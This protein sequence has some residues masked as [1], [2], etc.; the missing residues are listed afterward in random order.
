MINIPRSLIGVIEDKIDTSEVPL[1]EAQ[2]YPRELN[3]NYTDYL[4]FLSSAFTA[5]RLGNHRELRDAAF[6]DGFPSPGQ[7]ADGFD[8]TL[9]DGWS[10]RNTAIANENALT[11]EEWL[12]RT[13]RAMRKI[14]QQIKIESFISGA[15]VSIMDKGAINTQ[16]SL[17]QG[18][19][20]IAAQQ[21]NLNVKGDINLQG[22]VNAEQQLT[23]ATQGD[24]DSEAQLTATNQLT[25]D[26]ENIKQTGGAI[27]AKNVILKSQQD[28]D[29]IASNIAAEQNLS[30]EAGN[31]ISIGS[32][33][34]KSTGIRAGKRWN[35]EKR[36]AS[37]INAGGD[38]SLASGQDVNIKGSSVTAQ[39]AIDV[40][41]GRDINILSETEKRDYSYTQTTEKNPN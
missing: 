3:L 36:I 5:G 21:I 30:I 6:G 39:Q 8:N 17:H 18:G 16:N 13:Q 20:L 10:N 24:L 25:I 27:K 31:D 7:L 29:I 33:L 26:A 32:Q 35:S 41:A 2:L 37:E 14:Q 23:I 28:T 34:N 15:L 22:Q 11:R 12:Q 4:T 1:S 40:T 38:I 19:A 9:G